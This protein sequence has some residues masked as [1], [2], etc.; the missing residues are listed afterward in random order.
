MNSQQAKF[1]LQGY[2]PSGS[3]AGDAIFCEALEQA[4]KDPMLSKWLAQEQAFDAAVSA[5]LREISAPGGLREAIL[6]GARM[7]EAEPSRRVWWKHPA[8]LAAASVALIGAVTISL[9]SLQAGAGNALTEFAISDAIHA[10]RHGGKGEHVGALQAV[11]SRTD[12]RLSEHLPVD[13]ATLK[14]T[15][16][17]TL[18]VK[19]HDLLEVCFQRDGVWFH[20]YIAKRA[21]FP[22]VATTAVP[23]W[24][25]QDGV[26]SVTWVDASQVYVVVSET[27]RSVL[28]KLL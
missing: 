2:R 22:Q 25:N 15:G 23:S 5:K 17:R 8:W 10:E 24:F 1:I 18:A 26:G 16:C 11:L 7:T 19:G 3:D 27:S 6:A 14:K 4:R 20:C 12:V 9:W 21:D 13:F 28:E